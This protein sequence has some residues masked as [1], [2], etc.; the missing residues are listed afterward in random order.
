M[1]L[2]GDTVNRER[3]ALR[4]PPQRNFGPEQPKSLTFEECPLRAAVGIGLLT[5][6]G[7][8]TRDRETL[9]R[10]ST[11]SDGPFRTP[12]ETGSEPRL[13]ETGERSA[14]PAKKGGNEESREGRS[15]LVRV[16]PVVDGFTGKNPKLRD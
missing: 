4:R 11:D 7:R 10:L 2:I 15:R 8:H 16:N 3:A 9:G 13:S 1:Y 12:K 14:D 5:C 6:G